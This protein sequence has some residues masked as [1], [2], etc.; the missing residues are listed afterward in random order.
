VSKESAPAATEATDANAPIEWGKP[1]VITPI[2]D[3]LAWNPL[4]AA[5]MIDFGEIPERE[6]N[7]MRLIF[8]EPRMR[9]VYPD[10][11]GL[12]RTVVSYIRMEAARKPDDPRVA[13][14]V[15][16]LSIRDRNS[17]SG[18]PAQRVRSN[19][20]GRGPTIIR[21][22][23]RSHSSGTR[24]PPTQSQTS[25]SSSTPPNRAPPLSRH[26]AS[27]RRGPLISTTPREVRRSR[28]KSRVL[29]PP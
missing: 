2:H 14:I 1:R 7:F 12:A 29:P 6:R 16:E 3:V 28:T 22:S 10:W 21:L 8:T 11:E 25:S 15:G 26:S 17:D 20:E 18:G 24:S 13:E 9:A 19:G 5:L 4:A 27:S 23:A